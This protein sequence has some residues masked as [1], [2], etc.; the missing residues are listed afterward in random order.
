M[1]SLIRMDVA[2]QCCAGLNLAFQGLPQRRNGQSK[3][4]AGRLSSTPI[5]TFTEVAGPTGKGY[6]SGTLVARPFERRMCARDASA[7]FAL[8][9]PETAGMTI[10]EVVVSVAR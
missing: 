1:E 8:T 2:D 3:P 9:V 6:L 10:N 5:W 7:C 4:C